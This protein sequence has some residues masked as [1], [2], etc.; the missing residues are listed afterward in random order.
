MTGRPSFP[1][2]FHKLIALSVL[3]LLTSPSPSLCTSEVAPDGKYPEI[4]VE[5]HE[6]EGTD[7]VR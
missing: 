5:E 7:V 2:S 1:N 6:D 3:L 4:S